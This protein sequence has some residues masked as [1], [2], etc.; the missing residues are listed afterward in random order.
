MFNHS[1]QGPNIFGCPYFL[2]IILLA[3]P[4]V[5]SQHSNP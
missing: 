3:V 2:A 5:Y 4:P 1:W